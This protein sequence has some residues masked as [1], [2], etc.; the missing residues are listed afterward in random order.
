MGIIIYDE[1]EMTENQAHKIALKKYYTM[2][3]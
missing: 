3:D 1:I 2:E